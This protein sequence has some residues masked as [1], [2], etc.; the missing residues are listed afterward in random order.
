MCCRECETLCGWALRDMCSSH[1]FGIKGDPP[2]EGKV[3]QAWRA[4]KGQAIQGV[5]VRENKTFL[6]VAATPPGSGVFLS[7]FT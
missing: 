4:E 3:T 7:L 5:S 2:G 1:R 6:H